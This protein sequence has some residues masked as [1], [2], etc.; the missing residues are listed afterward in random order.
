[1]SYVRRIISEQ[2]SN[3][4]KIRRYEVETPR[5]S[6]GD[7]D[8]AWEAII[9]FD[10]LVVLDL[11]IQADA[12]EYF[13]NAPY[14]LADEIWRSALTKTHDGGFLDPFWRLKT[15][16]S[17][18]PKPALFYVFED[19]ERDVWGSGP[20]PIAVELWDE[21]HPL[22]GNNDWKRRNQFF[23]PDLQHWLREGDVLTEAQEQAIREY[24]AGID[25]HR[26][27]QKKLKLIAKR[28]PSKYLPMP[29]RRGLR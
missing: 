15:A 22:Y 29:S 2:S 18:Y 24:N 28:K 7:W 27:Q 8:E 1:M 3:N 6:D 19:A 5:T 12:T 17:Y 25:R 26:E 13:K 20:L 21:A 16:V 11:H 10:K 4:G 14:I 9:R 23:R